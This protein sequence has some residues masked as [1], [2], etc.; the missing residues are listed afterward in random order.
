MYVTTETKYYH[1]G[2][3]QDASGF[4]GVLK[5]NGLVDGSLEAH[6]NVSLDEDDIDGK[7]KR[8]GS[9][10]KPKREKASYKTTIL[11]MAVP[12]MVN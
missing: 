2:R 1:E 3:A 5:D 11:Q 9:K 10:K 8:K 4:V 6:E 7:S 12:V